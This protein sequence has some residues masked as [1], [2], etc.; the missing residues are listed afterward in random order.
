[1]GRACK[2]LLPLLLLGCDDSAPG[3][4][5]V[6]PQPLPGATATGSPQNKG[7]LLASRPSNV[8]VMLKGAEIGQ[9]PVKL[10]VSED[11]N[12]VLEQPGFVRQAV[13]VTRETRPNLIVDLVPSSTDCCPCDG[14][15]AVPSFEPTAA[16][17]VK[18]SKKRVKSDKVELSPE[19][20]AAAQAK[21]A[22]ANQ[23]QPAETE[24][25]AI[26]PAVEPP[27]TPPKSAQAYTTM[28]ALKRD[29]RAGKIDKATFRKFQNQIRAKRQVDLDKL[30]S[31]YK[32]G[33]IDKA[34]YKKRTREIKLKYEGE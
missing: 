21:L 23:K 1:M 16:P 27:N 19:L 18:S 24:S 26:K 6:A 22:A 3:A 11:M 7:V 25:G 15:Q 14:A 32:E 13:L 9:T 33:K 8:K 31:D 5:P 34:E 28:A 20:V 4:V 30:K 2:Y 29:I 12:L 17:K 10:L